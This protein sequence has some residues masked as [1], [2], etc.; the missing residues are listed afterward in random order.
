MKERL[1]PVR[2]SARVLAISAL[3]LASAFT[4]MLAQDPLTPSW[5]DAANKANTRLGQQFKGSPQAAP[6]CSAIVTTRDAA[7][8]IGS[9]H[10]NAPIPALDPRHT[11]TLPELIDIAETASP[12]GRIAW[13]EAK[14]S[15]E[16]A[17]VARA[18]YLPV[19][20]FIAEGSDSRF[21]VPFPKPIAP[22]GYVTVEDPTLF[23]QFQLEYSLLDFSRGSKFDGSKALEL[24][25]TLSLGRTHQTI[26]YATTAQFYA[27]QEAIGRLAAAQTILQTAETLL[28]NAQSQFDNGRATLPDVEN[29]QAGVAEA[30]YDLASAEGGVKKSILALTE[31]LGVEPTAEIDIQ[32][33]Q[34]DDFPDVLNHN[35][36]ELIRAAWRSRP[37]LLARAQELRSARDAYHTARS[38]YLP[39]VGINAAGG[40]TKMWPSADWGQLGPAN[41]ST[42]SAEATLRWEV[43][44]GARHHEMSAALAEQKAAAERQRATQDS[45]T[46]QV[47]DAYVD[48]QTAM[49][50]RRSAQSFLAASQ[51]SYDSSLD[52]YKYGVRSLVD[53]VQAE[54]QLA[55]ARLAVVRSQA[56]FMRSAVALSYATGDSVQHIESPSGVHP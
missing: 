33:Q 18:L 20:T 15:L 48:Y 21:I 36:D 19:L 56:E 26:A 32:A 45:V 54:K 5:N 53:V 27:V 28:Q 35:V 39:S 38:A 40:Q 34:E 42:W 49:E 17:G 11:Y 43:F 41:V 22:R 9:V 6:Q 7:R 10:P 55:Q 30:R 50:Q 52:A 3:L 16:R 23:A 46:R 12:E 29:A 4:P 8:C 44:N 51:T 24:A 47:W 2:R 37:D 14:R 13:A 1:N 31:S 25:S